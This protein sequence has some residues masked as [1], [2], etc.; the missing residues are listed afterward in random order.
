M[1]LKITRYSSQS[2]HNEHSYEAADSQTILECL[3]EIKHHQDATLSFRSGCRSGVCGSCA[4]RVN[5]KQQLACQCKAQEGD[6][7]E[8]LQYHAPIRDLI[9]DL[10]KAASTLH[11]SL[12]WLEEPVI[13]QVSKSDEKR[14]EIQSDCI[15]CD[16]CYSACPVFAVN[17]DF[18]GPFSLTRVFRYCSDSREGEEKNKIDAI[19]KNGVW[20][21]T[22][23]GE[24]TLACPQG[25]D[26]KSDIMN[27]RSK[28][29]MHGHSDPNMAAFN[30]GGGFAP[31]GGFNPGGGF[32]P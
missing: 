14:Y 29:V 13:K 20:D 4:V 25:I 11:A 22:L 16:S 8:S 1:K 18:L 6:H 26:P 17:P 19:Q 5:G 12:S 24:C 28:S 27:L 2:G 9:V 21:C 32:N 10:D 7:I 30:S 31:M 3:Q 15:L 23:C